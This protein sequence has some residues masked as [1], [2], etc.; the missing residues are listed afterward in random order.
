MLICELC[1]GGDL[2]KFLK[3]ER[4]ANCEMIASKIIKQLLRAVIYLHSK[5]IIHRDIK[6]HNILF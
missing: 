2:L 6:P 1:E 3:S 5:G 4:K